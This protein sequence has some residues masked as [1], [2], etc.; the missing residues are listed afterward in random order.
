MARWVGA[1]GITY[2]LL[3]RKCKEPKDPL[4]LPPRLKSLA[5]Y[6][7]SGGPL[8]GPSGSGIAA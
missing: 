7:P 2:S 4:L 8:L 3:K 1:L 5:V 6:K